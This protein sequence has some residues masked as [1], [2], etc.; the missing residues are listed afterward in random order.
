MRLGR[1]DKSQIS[2]SDSRFL[3]ASSIFILRHQVVTNGIIAESRTGFLLEAVFV[4][5]SSAAGRLADCRGSEVAM[6]LDCL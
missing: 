6:C 4:T 2:R 5:T 1:R 3:I